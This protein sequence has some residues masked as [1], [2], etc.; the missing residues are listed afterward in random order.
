MESFHWLK[1]HSFY[2][3]VGISYT[4]NAGL[5]NDYMFFLIDRLLLRNK[6]KYLLNFIFTKYLFNGIPVD[7]YICMHMWKCNVR[8]DLCIVG[9]KKNIEKSKVFLVLLSLSFAKKE[10][11]SKMTVCFF[12][13]FQLFISFFRFS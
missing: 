5:C 8:R 3:K 4:E 2:A 12:T 13:F 11:E 9:L 7:M 1:R 6:T 10:V